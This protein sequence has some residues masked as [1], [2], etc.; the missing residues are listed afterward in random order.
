[1]ERPDN[2]I[3]LHILQALRLADLPCLW[4]ILCLGMQRNGASEIQIINPDLFGIGEDDRTLKDILQ[5]PH[6][7]VELMVAQQLE[8]IG[9]ET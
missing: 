9:T 5:F 7:A 4:F 1:M 6:I 3:D 8:C 2:G